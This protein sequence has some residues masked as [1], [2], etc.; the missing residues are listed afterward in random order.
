MLKGLPAFQYCRPTSMEAL[1]STP[2]R[3]G[4]V[5]KMVGALINAIR[6]RIGGASLFSPTF[7]P[8]LCAMSVFLL[9]MGLSVR[10]ALPRRSLRSARTPV[11]PRRCS[12][13]GR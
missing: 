13:S 3:P 7:L 2:H 10:S 1:A 5:D 4:G 8:F 6:D 9:S 11:R 12:V